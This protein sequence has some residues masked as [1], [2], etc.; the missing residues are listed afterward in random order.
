MCRAHKRSREHCLHVTH[1]FEVQGV[2]LGCHKVNVHCLV[3]RLR[4]ALMRAQ[5]K[6]KRECDIRMN[7]AR[8]HGIVV[9]WHEC[10][11]PNCKYNAKQESSVKLQRAFL[12]NIGVRWWHCDIEGT[13]KGASIRPRR[14]ATSRDTRPTSTTSASDG[15]TNICLSA[16][17]CS[18]L[19]C[20]SMPFFHD[21]TG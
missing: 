15:S 5:H 20:F 4:R 14:T 18:S 10:P 11:A 8:V 17:E 12:H 21:D 3:A 13:S 6:A 19:L 7:K 9:T 2:R 16:H 1:T